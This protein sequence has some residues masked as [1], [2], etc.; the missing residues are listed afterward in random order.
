MFVVNEEVDGSGTRE[1]L[2]WFMKSERRKYKS[3]CGVLVEPTGL[4]DVEI[5]H[6]GNVFVKLTVKGDSGHGSR[7]DKINTNAVLVIGEILL[8]LKKLEKQLKRK[9]ADKIIGKPSIGIGTSISAGSEESPNKFAD[10]CSAILDVRTTPKLHGKVIKLIK[11]FLK[12]YPVEVSCLFDPVSYGYT[13]KND[14]IVRILKE[15]VP[16][17]KV[18]V[19]S[20]STDQC[21]FTRH[22]IPAVVFG[23][24]EKKCMHKANEYCIVEK[25]NTATGVYL[26]LIEKWSD[27]D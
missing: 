15:V 3:L 26:K 19:S 6:R 12:N 11:S 2:E 17:L 24:G 16:R 4:K 7:P 9:Y 13:D 25:I 23:P 20:G 8:K 14:V 18:T 27:H 5:G 21:F 10:K 22:G 1:V